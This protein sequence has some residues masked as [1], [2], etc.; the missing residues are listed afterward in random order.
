MLVAFDA[1][2]FVRKAFVSL[3]YRNIK[4]VSIPGASGDVSLR[5]HDAH[6]KFQ[7]KLSILE[8]FSLELVFLS[9]FS[10]CKLCNRVYV[11]L[12]YHSTSFAISPHVLFIGKRKK[13]AK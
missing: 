6:S 3:S 2:R 1:V 7:S 12:S 5:L 10:G 11:G 9:R 8:D 13:E 4:I